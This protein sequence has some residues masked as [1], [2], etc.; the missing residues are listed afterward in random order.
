M[1]DKQWVVLRYADA[2]T[3]HVDVPQP[4]FD[5]LKST[6]FS[7]QEIVEIT[8]TVAAYNMVSR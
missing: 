8:V 7:N 5:E 1:N 6:G 2:M 4:L 3:R